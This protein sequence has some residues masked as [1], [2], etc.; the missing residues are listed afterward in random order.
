MAASGHSTYTTANMAAYAADHVIKRDFKSLWE[1]AHPLIGTIVSGKK[2]FNRAGEPKDLTALLPVQFD[3][4]TTVVD[5]V[6]DAS[7][8][9][10]ISPVASQGDTQATYIYSRY[11]GAF[12]MEPHQIQLVINGARGDILQAR[13]KQMMG[14]WK[15]AVSGDLQGASNAA[16]ANVIGLRYL[17]STSNAPGGITQ[18]SDNAYWQAKVNTDGGAFSLQP[19]NDDFDAI[20]VEGR[21][22]PDC[23]LLSHNA[24]VNMFGLMRDQVA[25]LQRIVGSEKKVKFG[26]PSFIY[27]DM[28]CYP[29]PDLGAALS[30][31]GGYQ[32]LSSDSFYWMSTSDNVQR[33]G[34]PERLQGTGAFEYYYD[35]WCCLANDDPAC[36][37]Y[38]TAFTG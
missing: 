34:P 8:L 10:A 36:N 1:T 28:D 37:A 12:W 7:A 38:R 22:I 31:T 17:L 13:I 15:K 11:H 3:D 20:G 2:N 24:T 18:S 35:M 19:V 33:V 16:R 4:L 14:S 32:M 29:E 25:S 26:F 23:L 5:G 6:A 30:T 21:S 27:L 9:T